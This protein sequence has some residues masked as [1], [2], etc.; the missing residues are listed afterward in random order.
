MAK[1]DNKKGKGKKEKKTKGDIIT[2]IILILLMIIIILGAFA[3]V[4]KYDIAGFGS[5]VMR[6]ILKDVPVLKVI[7]PEEEKEETDSNYPYKTLDEAVVDIQ[8][9]QYEIDKL[10]KENADNKNKVEDL[11]KENSKLKKIEKEIEAFESRVKDYENE[12]VFGENALDISEYQKYYEQI[13]P[14]R[15]EE[16]YKQVIFK[17]SAE[18]K[19]KQLSNTYSKMDAGAAAA[20]LEELDDSIALVCDVLLDMSEKNRAAIM[21]EMTPEFAAKVT[22]RIYSQTKE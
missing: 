3:L 17:V 16:L 14:E 21:D 6:P 19:A 22:K 5:N 10:K 15:A 1:Q 7:L 18:E 4:V 11:T 2:T 13:D 9:M 12:V 8:K 20:A